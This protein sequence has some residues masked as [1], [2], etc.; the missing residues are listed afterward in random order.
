MGVLLILWG[1]LFWPI[2]PELWDIWMDD[3]NNSHG[4]REGIGQPVYIA[5]AAGRDKGG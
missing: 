4:G 5:G 2:V 1:V 3:S